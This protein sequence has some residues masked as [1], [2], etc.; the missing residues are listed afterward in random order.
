MKLSIIIPTYNEQ[1]TIRKLIE[2]VQSVDYPVEYEIIIIDDASA[3]RTLEKEFLIKLK[4]KSM[5]KNIRIFK[6]RINR[7][8][9][10]SIRKGIKRAKGDIIIIQDADMEYNPHDIPKLIEPILKGEAAAVYGSR[11]LENPCPDGMVIPN[12]IANKI[13]TKL[14]N[15][16]FGI[17]L[18]DEATC[19]KAFDAKILKSL[20][21]KANGFTFCPEVTALLAKRGVEI[22]ELPISYHARTTKQGKKVRPMDLVFAVL[23]LLW[24]RAKK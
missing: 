3:D 14:A 7:G 5:E 10:F 21:L 13:L 15:V 22:K 17:S 6:N 23:M 18:T 2:H 19:Y 16:L 11:F 4:N 24:Q 12:W 9:G 8:K 1:N 20:D